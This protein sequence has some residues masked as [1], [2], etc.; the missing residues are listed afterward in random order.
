MRLKGKTEV[1][2]KNLPQC[3]QFHMDWPGIEPGLKPESVSLIY[4][5]HIHHFRLPET[6]FLR[7]LW[8]KGFHR[9]FKCRKQIPSNV[10]WLEFR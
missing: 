5:I 8:Y 10:P 7:R 4:K 6:L 9:N 3:H 1:L 2:G